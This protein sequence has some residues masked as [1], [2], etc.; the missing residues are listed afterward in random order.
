MMEW[1]PVSDR[2]PSWDDLHK[3]FLVTYV[4]RTGKRHV[5]K[6]MWWGANLWGKNVNGN[7]IAWAEMPEPYKEETND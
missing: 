2:H 3:Q 7:V 5:T 6:T 1:I 4:T